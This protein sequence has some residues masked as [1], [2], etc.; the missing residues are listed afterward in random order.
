MCGI[1]GASNVEESSVVI[2]NLLF[3]LQHR[4]EEAAGM[5]VMDDDGQVHE[6]KGVGWVEKVFG[7]G[8]VQDLPGKS[9]IGHVRYST[10]GASSERN[11]QPIKAEF[12][13]FGH[14]AIA[15]NGDLVGSLGIKSQVGGYF[16][17]GTDTELFFRF[18]HRS[19]PPNLEKRILDSAVQVRGSYAAVVLAQHTLYALVDPWGFRPLTFGKFGQ[20]YIVSSEGYDFSRLG[21]SPI[22]DVR[23]GEMVV[24]EPG[25][26]PR[27]EII[28]NTNPPH[29]PCVL[30]LIYFSSSASR[31]FGK[32][33]DAVRIELGRALAREEKSD[34][35]EDIDWVIGVPD[36]GSV[37]AGG[38][39]LER[40][41]PLM[42]GLFRNHYVGRTFIKP[43]QRQREMDAR[44]KLMPLPTIIRGKRLAVVDDSIIRGTV[45]N[46]IVHM[47]Y[48]AGAR[49]V[50][51]R[52]PSPMVSY[53]C[54]YGIDMKTEGEQ[55]ANQCGRDVE[56]I[57][58]QIG[59]NSLRYISIEGMLKAAS[60]GQE[61][62]T[63]CS[64]CFDGNYPLI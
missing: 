59:C 46:S 43:S 63:F 2:S 55:I 47:L 49:E 53:P 54:L 33:V 28:P 34:G 18:I 60:Q 48:D 61:G 17:T 26:E 42:P 3:S 22:R 50:H 52:I 23:P 25:K 14:I 41:V 19:H 36:S 39:A 5:V 6:R 20:G 13:R 44:A 21:I 35:A 29:T 1:V 58:G 16:Q 38:Y 8:L 64:A 56:K 57:R 30:E 12:S 40:G 11:V 32:D 62:A 45:I 7:N 10:T 31:V 37:A 27:S 4:G 15:H 24:F 9:G 51:V